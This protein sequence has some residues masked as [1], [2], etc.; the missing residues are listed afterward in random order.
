MTANGITCVEI[1]K[2]FKIQ[3]VGKD[4]F[5]DIVFFCYNTFPSGKITLEIG[6]NVEKSKQ[7]SICKFSNNQKQQRLN[8]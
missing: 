3:M 7:T 8:N 5:P 4:T 6:L 2:R 1:P